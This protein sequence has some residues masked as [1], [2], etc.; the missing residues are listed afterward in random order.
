MVGSDK[1]TQLS[2]YDELMRNAITSWVQMV[3]SNP[4]SI[5][6]IWAACDTTPPHQTLG[7]Y[8]VELEVNFVGMFEGRCQ[9]GLMQRAVTGSCE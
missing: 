9:Q 8:Q 7:K 5:I 1:L 4:T 2:Q 6:R 3:E